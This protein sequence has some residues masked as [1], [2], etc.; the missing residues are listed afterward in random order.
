V[1]L[2]IKNQ[3]FI[4]RKMATYLLTWN[5]KKWHWWDNLGD[6]FKR[7]GDSYVGKWS[8]GNSKK[9]HAGDRVFLIRLGKDPRGI[10]ASGWATSNVYPGSHW[11]ERLAESGKDAL[12]VDIRLDTLLNPGR[13][14]ILARRELDKGTLGNMHWDSQASGFEIPRDVAAKIEDLWEQFLSEGRRP[15]PI[16]EPSALEGI[17]T[18]TV[19]YSRGRNRRLR[20]LALEKSNSICCVCGVD[21]SKVLEGSGVRVLQVHHKKQLGATDTPSI[22]QLSD[23]AVVCA[24]CHMLI[25]MNPKEALTVERLKRMLQ[26]Q[27][28]Q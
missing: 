18:E 10:V 14:K 25:H 12:Y 28:S 8:S 15:I 5:P 2:S 13:E 17:K 24:N 6:S 22:T 7:V 1:A 16:A 21:Y 26:K 23:L 9:I 3:E 4:R 20:D 27:P 11:D 19:K